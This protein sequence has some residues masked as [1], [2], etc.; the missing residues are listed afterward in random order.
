M[1]LVFLTSIFVSCE[2][3]SA[4]EKDTT[5]QLLAE[6]MIEDG[7]FF[8]S[9]AAFN[10]L[11]TR[12]TE[13]QLDL[14]PEERSSFT[15]EFMKAVYDNDIIT[16]A[17][18]LGVTPNF[19]EHLSEDFDVFNE[20][21]LYLKEFKHLQENQKDDVI[22]YLTNSSIVK[23]QIN[24]L[25]TDFISDNESNVLANVNAKTDWECIPDFLGCMFINVGF[26]SLSTKA[27]DG[28]NNNLQLDIS[29]YS[30]NNCRR[31]IGVVAFSSVSISCI[32]QARKC[33]RNGYYD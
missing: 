13:I 31:V 2:K 5:G 21:D 19:M 12:S 17:N 25:T 30:L 3:E 33:W 10:F 7:R 28:T 26:S 4:I 29:E 20:S 24:K 6:K 16:Q 18:L 23:N 22:E 15:S 32:N 9:E 8:K 11:S 1:A 14:T 27:C